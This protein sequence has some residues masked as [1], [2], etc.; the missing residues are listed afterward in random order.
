MRILVFHGLELVLMLL[1]VLLS[2]L[3]CVSLQL[4]DSLS[5]KLKAFFKCSFE[6][7]LLSCSPSLELGLHAKLVVVVI[8]P[9]SSCCLS[10][11]MNIG[12]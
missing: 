4:P 10:P 3:L 12:F 7:L 6:Y 11:R 5:L 9:S 8:S 2:L 1:S